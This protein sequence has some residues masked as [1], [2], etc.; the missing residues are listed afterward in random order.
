MTTVFG[1]PGRVSPPNGFTLF[2]V[3]FVLG[4][5]AAVLGLAVAA[6]YHGR[7]RLRDATNAAH[8][9]QEMAI[10]TDRLRRDIRRAAGARAG[11]QSL[12]LA[13]PDGALVIW[14]VREGRLVRTGPGGRWT[15]RAA[16]DGLD[17]RVSAEGP[18]APLV[19]VGVR[20]AGRGPAKRRIMYV[21]ASPRVREANR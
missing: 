14:Q 1:R 17:V 21:G 8:A 16:V 7:K 4:I 10:A 19:E 5:L 6:I 11:R 12:A 18:A 9:R 13:G 20:L 15:Y 2:E 3:I